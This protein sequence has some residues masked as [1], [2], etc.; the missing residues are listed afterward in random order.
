MRARPGLGGFFVNEVLKITKG[1]PGCLPH[2]LRQDCPF[3]GGAIDRRMNPLCRCCRRN[4]T[5]TGPLRWK[6]PIPEG[7]SFLHTV[8]EFLCE[9]FGVHLTEI[10]CGGTPGRVS[11]SR[12]DGGI[13]PR[14]RQVGKMTAMAFG[15][16]SGPPASA[17]QIQSSS[18]SSREPDIRLP[19]MH[20]AQ[21]ASP[22]V[23]RGGA[24]HATKRRR[25]SPICW[26]Q[27]LRGV[28]PLLR[29]HGGK[30]ARERISSSL[31][32]EQLAHEFHRRGWTAIEP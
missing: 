19:A 11:P 9:H 14:H 8:T 30:S 20:T 24:S 17:K 13:T 4:E 6:T 28:F 2:S 5:P 7:I 21:W 23:R 1:E 10:H 27:S 25:S 18:T 26:T 22:S 32:S 29:R 31:P 16:R 3:L 15:Q 12:R